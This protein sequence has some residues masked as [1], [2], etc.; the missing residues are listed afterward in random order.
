MGYPFTACKACMLSVPPSQHVAAPMR[1]HMRIRCVKYVL[2][3]RLWRAKPDS[4]SAGVTVSRGLAASRQRRA[5]S[6]SACLIER[7]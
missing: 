6:E 3:A 5:L 4:I 2:S 7:S 1:L